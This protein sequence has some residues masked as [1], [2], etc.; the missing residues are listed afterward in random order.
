MAGQVDGCATGPLHQ[1]PNVSHATAHYHC[2][3]LPVKL[4]LPFFQEPPEFPI[5]NTTRTDPPYEKARAPYAASYYLPLALKRNPLSTSTSP[6]ARHRHGRLLPRRRGPLP[7]RA[8]PPPQAPPRLPSTPSLPRPRLHRRP[9][10]PLALAPSLTALRRHRRRGGLLAPEPPRKPAR[11]GVPRVP[12]RR[13]PRAPP[14]SPCGRAPAARGGR[15]RRGQPR[16][17]VRR[18]GVARGAVRRAG[19]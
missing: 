18:A 7:R 1:R 3:A 11:R 4:R 8:T 15:P 16:H 9:L 2:S 19:G 14:P 13:R 17:G 10:R 5:P 6:P 12:G